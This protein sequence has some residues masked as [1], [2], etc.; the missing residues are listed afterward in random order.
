VVL[1]SPFR[2]YLLDA[3]KACDV[4]SL[5]YDV[6]TR[7]EAADEIALHPQSFLCI[8]RTAAILPDVDEYDQ[9]VYIKAKQLMN[10]SIDTKTYQKDQETRFYLYRMIWEDTE[11]V[12][13]STYDASTEPSSSHMQLGLVAVVSTD[14]YR[15]GI[16]HR[17]ENTR[18]EK[19]ADRIDHIKTLGAQASPVLMTHRYNESISELLVELQTGSH[20]HA[21][22]YSPDNIRHT[23]WAVD[24]ARNAQVELAY[25]QLD[26]LYIADGHHRAEAAAQI[27]DQ[28][29]FAIIFPADMLHIHAYNRAVKDTNGLS[30]EQFLKALEEFFTVEKPAPDELVSSLNPLQRGEY[31]LLLEEQWYRLTLDESI[32]PSEVLAA[33]D[34]SVLHD[35]VLKPLLGIDDPRTSPR[36]MYVG[37]S[38]GLD[39]LFECTRAFGDKDSSPLAFAMRAVT[40]HDFFNVADSGQLMPPKSTWFAPKPRSGLL[41]YS[42]A[43]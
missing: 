26:N 36:I 34:V 6:F 22:F 25:Q 30:P 43:G 15:S 23:V 14:E 41:F 39:A 16:I 28:G 12:V 8:D 37:G 42:H 1:V 9:E 24:S 4:A 11:T 20:L 27:G 3:R 10:E 29:I 19:L 7:E 18:P 2:A 5:P 32:R 33:L 31:S 40:F 35:K 38:L 21:D 17:H 13:D